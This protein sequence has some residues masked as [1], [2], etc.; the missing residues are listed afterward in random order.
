ML[1]LMVDWTAIMTAAAL[2]AVL[3]GA[4]WALNN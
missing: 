3:N 2:D 1:S 4:V